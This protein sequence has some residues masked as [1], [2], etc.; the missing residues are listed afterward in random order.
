MLLVLNAHHDVV[1]FKLPQAPGGRRWHCIID[2]NTPNRDEL[3]PFEFN[4]DYMATGRSL[5]AFI[6]EP[7]DGYSLSDEAHQAFQHVSEAFRRAAAERVHIVRPD[8][9]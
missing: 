3:V 6:L 5:L 2:T 9:G 7:E 4:T 8:K 1:N